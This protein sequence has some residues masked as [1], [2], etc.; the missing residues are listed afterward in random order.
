MNN[1]NSGSRF[2][3]RE[4]KRKSNIVL[5][6][7]IGIVFVLII[8]I[9]Y[10][11]ATGGKEEA[12]S[13]YNEPPEIKLANEKNKEKAVEDKEQ[14]ESKDTEEGKEEDLKEDEPT[15]KGEEESKDTDEANDESVSKDPFE[16][17]TITEGPPNSNVKEVIENP[18]WEPVGTTQAGEHAADYSKNSQDWAEMKK[19]LSYATAIPESE[20]IIWF[21]G[22]NGSPNDAVGTISP[23]DK[24]AK[25]KVYITWID[26]QGWKPTKVEKIK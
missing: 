25:Y 12:S 2:E 26:G 16:E 22:N 7:L 24:S 3:K 8:V 21:L 15:D 10:Q 14:E 1:Y 17:A 11:L 13:K 9:G 20:M 4:K 18:A 5:N 23:K 19:A 6:A